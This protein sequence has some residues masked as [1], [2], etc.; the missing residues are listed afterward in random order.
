MM[1]LSLTLESY[2]RGG[3]SYIGRLFDIICAY[4]FPFKEISTRKLV[5]LRSSAG[6]GPCDR[7]NASIPSVEVTELS[8]ISSFECRDNINCINR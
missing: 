3:A 4:F 5:F 8:G 6:G 7:S 2:C 1:A